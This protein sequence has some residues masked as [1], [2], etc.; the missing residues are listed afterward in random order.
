MRLDRVVVDVGHAQEHFQ[1]LVRLFF[2]QEAQAAKIF[3]G[4]FVGR[5]GSP[6]AAKAVT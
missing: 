4:E 6:G 2:E 1:R 3:F 5:I